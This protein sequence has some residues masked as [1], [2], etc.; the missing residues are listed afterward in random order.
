MERTALNKIFALQSGLY[1]HIY[2]DLL[3]INDREFIEPR[4]LVM[5]M[6]KVSEVKTGK[7][8]LNAAITIA[9]LVMTYITGFY[10][11]ALLLFLTIWDLK[12]IK[13][14]TL[15]LLKSNCMPLNNIKSIQFITGKLGFHELDMLIVNDEGKQMQKTMRL[16]DSKNEIERALIIL[17]EAGFAIENPMDAKNEKLKNAESIT[18]NENEKL[19]LLEKE[20][21]IAKNN[22]YP[23]KAEY[24]GVN[25]FLFFVLMVG[26]LASIAAKT[27]IIINKGQ[28]LWVDLLVVFMFLL[29]LPLPFSLLNK[30]TSDVMQKDEI[31]SA[32]IEKKRKKIFVVIESKSGWKLPLKRKVE[33]GSEED[34]KKAVEAVLK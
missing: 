5:D 34:A 16:Y 19:Y 7:I 31:L 28:V 14:Q 4:D 25:N 8:L 1:C 33:F 29:F 27:Y 17:N 15:P 24:V 26:I 6:N 23:Q 10:P 20:I 9:I 2:N 18:I 13:R 11:L 12:R 30:S 32:K 21:V 22:V 3:V